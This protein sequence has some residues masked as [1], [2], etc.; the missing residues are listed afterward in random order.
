MH[1]TV[2]NSSPGIVIHRTALDNHISEV[3]LGMVYN[4]KCEMTVLPARAVTKAVSKIRV[5]R[6]L[7][8]GFHTTANYHKYVS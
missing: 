4:E 1:K 3:L 2:Y 7:R 5:S 8:K 6:N